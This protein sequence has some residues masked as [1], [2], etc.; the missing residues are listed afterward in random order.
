MQYIHRKE[1]PELKQIYGKRKESV[2]RM[3]FPH[4]DERFFLPGAVELAVET[5]VSFEGGI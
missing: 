4:H 2:H 5:D 1:T 3:K